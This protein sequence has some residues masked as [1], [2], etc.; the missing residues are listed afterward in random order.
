MFKNFAFFLK[1]K[2]VNAVA[3]IVWL[4]GNCF[5]VSDAFFYNGLSFI[6]NGLG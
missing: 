3:D 5:A 6:G 1:A 2:F 4:F